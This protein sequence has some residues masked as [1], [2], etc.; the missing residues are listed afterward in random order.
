[1]VV[2]FYYQLNLFFR[3]INMSG[4]VCVWNDLDSGSYTFLVNEDPMEGAL[5][6]EHTE[7]AHSDLARIVGLLKHKQF[8]FKGF[9]FLK[10]CQIRLQVYQVLIGSNYTAEPK[11]ALWTSE[12]R[13]AISTGHW[14]SVFQYLTPTA[15]FRK[16]RCQASTN[17]IQSWTGSQWVDDDI[18][19][20]L[21][22][23]CVSDGNQSLADQILANRNNLICM[24]T[25]QQVPQAFSYAPILAMMPVLGLTY[26]LV[27]L[28]SNYL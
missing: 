1:M 21:C 6:C 8:D 9:S 22:T 14:I 13:Q 12:L 26:M 23:L 4:Y 2:N 7:Y 25:G 10:D 16:I 19:S 5:V 11:D 17:E 3:A 28:Y 24:L 15:K 20:K 27:S 18:I